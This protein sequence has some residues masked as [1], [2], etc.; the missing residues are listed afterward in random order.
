MYFFDKISSYFV[1]SANNTESVH[2]VRTV[3]KYIL[4]T[5]GFQTILGI[6]FLY[7][8]N[9]WTA[10]ALIGS[11]VLLLPMFFWLKS[12]R[13][14]LL[15]TG[16]IGILML[17]NTGLIL[18]F[19]ITTG[20][21]YLYF[22][23]VVAIFLLFKKEEKGAKFSLLTLVFCCFVV[24][25]FIE[26]PQQYQI[27]LSA[28]EIQWQRTGFG[29][30]AL[31]L[32]ALGLKSLQDSFQ[33]S[34]SKEKTSTRKAKNFS[35]ELYEANRNL[36]GYIEK[37]REQESLRYRFFNTLSHE[38]RTPLN[39]IIGLINV[40][41]EQESIKHK[42]IIDSLSYSSNILLFLVND[43]LDLAKFNDSAIPIQA[44][45]NDL[46]LLGMQVQNIF[47]ETATKKGIEFHLEIDERLPKK[48]LFDLTRL[49]QCL[50]NLVNNAIKFTQK[51]YVKLSASLISSEDKVMNVL[52][53]VEDTGKGISPEVGE[54]IFKPFVQETFDVY[55]DYGGTGLGLSISQKIVQSMGG[56]LQYTS[57]V[58]EG[59]R[60]YFQ[61]QLEESPNI[62]K[63]TAT[64]VEESGLSLADLKILAVD[65]NPIN[66][67]VLKK[68]LKKSGSSVLT[69]KDGKEAIKKVAV[70]P[71]IDLIL[72]DLQMPVMDGYV[73]TKVLRQ[74]GLQ[75]P[76]IALSATL[77]S[78]LENMNEKGFSHALVKPFDVGKLRA[79]ISR[80]HA[81]NI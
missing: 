3:L 14:L 24:V 46:F 38:L 4:F 65:D 42:S 26:L 54:K 40:L 49:N 41:K 73:A 52:F 34:L 37:I 23:A 51:G 2:E 1:D 44:R 7:Y 81:G 77:P 56:H 15:K 10:L 55:K 68:L 33:S 36:E 25:N 59:T 78:N 74:Q 48:L 47:K 17:I 9:Y 79:I 5:F 18:S 22:T 60:F 16:M 61:L 75:I 20:I 8:E 27:H 69:A 13:F 67:L 39:G 32:S 28:K 63:A 70:H 11:N 30:C 53:T 58:D 21:D 43:V 6:A 71:D 72:M 12:G 45:P 62:T 76:I 31:M 35:L 29:L 66:L 57:K 19:G 50:N 80:F 64:K